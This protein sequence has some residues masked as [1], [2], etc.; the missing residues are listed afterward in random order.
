MFYCFLLIAHTNNITTFS[1]LLFY[2]PM[3]A[4]HK[5]R[6]N[7]VADRIFQASLYNGAPDQIHL[8]NNASP[9]MQGNFGPL[10]A[11]RVMQ[12]PVSDAKY[13]ALQTKQINTHAVTTLTRKATP[14]CPRLDN[15]AENHQLRIMKGHHPGITGWQTTFH[16]SD[17]GCGKMLVLTML[18]CCLP[19]CVAHA[20][21]IMVK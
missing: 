10:N 19:L 12:N 17:L 8:V 7:L 6:N 15:R 16:T 13:Q 2:G 5:A 11:P 9:K 20:F 4:V 14:W 1:I 21:K 18:Y 3:F